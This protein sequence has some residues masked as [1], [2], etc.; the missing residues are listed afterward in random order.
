MGADTLEGV[1]VEK[2]RLL[3]KSPGRGSERYGLITSVTK[4]LWV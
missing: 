2:S 3:S 1:T 4:M